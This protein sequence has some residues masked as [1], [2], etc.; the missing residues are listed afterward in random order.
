MDPPINF[1]H[2]LTFKPNLKA[3]SFIQST[4]LFKWNRLFVNIDQPP[5]FALRAADSR[6]TWGF[7]VDYNPSS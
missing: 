3:C 2:W 6:V 1:D 7:G 5:D 4:S